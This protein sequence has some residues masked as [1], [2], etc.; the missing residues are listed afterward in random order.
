MQLRSVIYISVL[1][2]LPNEYFEFLH[3]IYNYLLA[4][5]YYLVPILLIITNK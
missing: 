3:T 1:L 4:T 2:Y 5:T